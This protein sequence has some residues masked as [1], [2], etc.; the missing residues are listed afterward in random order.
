MVRGTNFDR[1]SQLGAD[2]GGQAG[3]MEKG[4]P[5]GDFSG[6]SFRMWL[7]LRSLFSI[8]Q[9]LGIQKKKKKKK[10]KKKNRRFAHQDQYRPTSPLNRCL[11]PDCVNVG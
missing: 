6:G 2:A 1:C 11:R 8:A 3:E 4:F 10:K 7:P 9:L 5:E